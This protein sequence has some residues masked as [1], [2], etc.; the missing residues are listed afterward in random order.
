MPPR[1]TRRIRRRERVGV[2]ASPARGALTLTLFDG[3]SGG[4]DYPVAGGPELRRVAVVARASGGLVGRNLRADAIGFPQ[5]Q[6]EPGELLLRHAVC[7]PPL[8]SPVGS[9]R[10]PPGDC[11]GQFAHATERLEEPLA[12]EALAGETARRVAAGVP[13]ILAEGAAG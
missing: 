8:L 6:R 12:K 4:G 1:E 9:A 7:S 2:P 11:G 13:P 5:D 3:G 10:R